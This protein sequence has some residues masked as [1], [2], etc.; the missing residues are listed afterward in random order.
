MQRCRQ[1][2]RVRR[3][4][5]FLAFM[6]GAFTSAMP[7]EPVEAQSSAEDWY[8]S[9]KGTPPRIGIEVE[10]KVR[11]ANIPNELHLRQILAQVK[12]EVSEDKSLDISATTRKQLIEI[13]D[14]P[15]MRI[16][17]TGRQSSLAHS[18]GGQAID[19]NTI[20]FHSEGFF[21][22]G[23]PKPASEISQILL[24]ELGH[25]WQKR[26]NLFNLPVIQEKWPEQLEVEL[27]KASD[28][29][30]R[31]QTQLASLPAGG[32]QAQTQQR[33]VSSR[34]RQPSRLL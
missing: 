10:E 18:T 7:C 15:N 14:D 34:G 24:H 6:I 8:R 3:W 1:T 16:I 33:T 13:L 27:K 22:L 30:T 17:Y 25:V 28:Q 26:H 31:C 11:D 23:A 5:L 21:R 20:K 12:Y 9:G 4:S 2:G 19:K 32:G 29:F